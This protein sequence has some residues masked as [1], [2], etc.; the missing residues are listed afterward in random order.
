V[1][2]R[3]KLRA[4]GAGEILRP[5][6]PKSCGRRRLHLNQQC[7]RIGGQLASSAAGAIHHDIGE[8]Q[9]LRACIQPEFDDD[10]P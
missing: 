3:C 9:R 7:R 1:P 2:A 8:A 4:W 10:C 5:C 6:R